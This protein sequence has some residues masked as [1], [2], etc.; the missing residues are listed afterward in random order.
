MAS[1][2]GARKPGARCALQAD[3]Q[4]ASRDHGS[5]GLGVL[6]TNDLEGQVDTRRRVLQYQAEL[7]RGQG[8]VP[9]AYEASSLF[10]SY[11]TRSIPC[12]QIGQTQ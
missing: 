5:S 7:S 4:V 11:H 12:Q 10:R 8:E 9:F 3:T 1:I 2:F 6:W